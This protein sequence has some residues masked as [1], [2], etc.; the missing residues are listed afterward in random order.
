VTVSPCI[1]ICSLGRRVA[2]FALSEPVVIA[3]AAVF[4]PLQNVDFK[5]LSPCPPKTQTHT[6]GRKQTPDKECL[7]TI[8]FN[9]DGNCS[10]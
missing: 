9:V 1:R 7:I 5:I 3:S 10:F 8:A 2:L 4:L 6:Q